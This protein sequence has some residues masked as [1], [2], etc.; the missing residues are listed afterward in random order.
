MGRG[1]A[2]AKQIKVARKLKY[3]AP[4]TDLTALERELHSS[5]GDYSYDSSP[6]DDEGDDQDDEDPYA[7][8]AAY[9][10]EGGEDDYESW[11]AGGRG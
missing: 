2:K 3:S 6:A 8:Y 5:R 10:A 7:A 11:A 9:A 4:S 1:R